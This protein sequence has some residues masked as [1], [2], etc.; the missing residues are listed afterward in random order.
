MKPSPAP[1]ETDIRDPDLRA[2]MEL[3]R[4][5]PEFADVL[6]YLG[7]K[8]RM[9]DSGQIQSSQPRLNLDQIRDADLLKRIEGINPGDRIGEHNIRAAI[10][11]QARRDKKAAHLAKLKPIA[12]RRELV[13]DSLTEPFSDENRYFVHSVLATCGLP[14]RKPAEGQGEYLSEYGRSSLVVQAGYLK[15]P[16]SGRMVKQGLPYGPKARLLMLHIC[17]MA[18]RQNTNEIEIADSMSAFIR[19]LGFEVTG[20]A[21]GTIAQFKEQLHRL[22]ASR[23]QIGLWKGDTTTTISTQPIEAFDV[24][25]P[26]DPDQKMLWN[27]RLIMDEKFFR[28]LK[29]HALPVDMRTMR[30]FAHSAKQIDM[31][32]WLFARLNQLEKPV[33][34][35]WATLKAQ[36]GRDIQ[37]R[38]RKFRQSFS[39]DWKAIEEVFPKLRSRLTDNGILLHPGDGDMLL[40]PAKRVLPARK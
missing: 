32:L 5:T 34:I 40:V 38:D 25:L 33:P 24:W 17:T 16:V 20:G 39:D 3:A 29:V 18:L 15:D 21:R 6:R 19:E 14:Y 7:T 11:E 30:A 26:T 2:E 23:M 4:G 8:Q 12:R 37:S 13:R 28:T 9:R 22:A 1:S 36:F 35:S 10:D 27:T 31:V